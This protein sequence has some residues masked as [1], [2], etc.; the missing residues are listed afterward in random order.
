MSDHF[1]T[2]RI[3]GFNFHFRSLQRTYFIFLMHLPLPNMISDR[4]EIMSVIRDWLFH[5]ICQNPMKSLAIIWVSASNYLPLSDGSSRLEVFCKKGVL[6]IFA[7]IAGTHL[8]LRS[9]FNKVAGLKPATL[10]KRDSGTRVFQWILWI[11]IEHLWWLPPFP[12][13]S[14]EVITKK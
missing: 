6:K 2:L 9:F 11:F 3:K 1:G 8:C 4:V 7:K 10:L 5:K 14:S 12:T 13:R